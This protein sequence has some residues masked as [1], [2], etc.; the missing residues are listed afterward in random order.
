VKTVLVASGDAVPGDARWLDDAA[1]VVAV[2]GGA[3]WLDAI[4][5]APNLLVGDLDSVSPELVRRLDGASIPIERHRPDKDSSDLELAL[6]SARSRGAD[7]IVVLGAIGGGRLDHELANVLLVC[8]QSSVPGGA[9]LQIVR[10]DT[11]LRALH[12]GSEM[13]IEAPRGALVTLLSVGDAAEGVTT[14]GLRYPLND[15]PLEPGSSRGL[16]NVVAAHPASIRV[17]RGTLLVIETE[18]EEMTR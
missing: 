1:L 7:E 11:R 12:G 18:Q 2:D 4:G 14:R 8:A 16:S 3:A 10:G 17:R 9:R 13:A 15:E 5:R 6:A